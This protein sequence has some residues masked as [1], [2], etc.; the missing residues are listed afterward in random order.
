MVK[1]ISDKVRMAQRLKKKRKGKEY[2]PDDFHTLHPQEIQQLSG[3]SYHSLLDQYH[4]LCL[5]YQQSLW[6]KKKESTKIEHYRLSAYWKFCSA[7]KHTNYWYLKQQ[8][9]V[10][11]RFICKT[12]VWFI[13]S[14]ISLPNYCCV[15][16]LHSTNIQTTMNVTALKWPFCYHFTKN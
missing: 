10:F 5:Y 11:I 15:F 1:Q 6:K 9:S 7:E 2:R 4:F 16:C 12:H 14:S 8:Q 3:R 13:R